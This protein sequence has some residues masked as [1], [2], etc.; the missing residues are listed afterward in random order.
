MRTERLVGK[1]L[2]VPRLIWEGS[3]GRVGQVLAGERFIRV[4]GVRRTYRI[5]RFIGFKRLV[6][7][8]LEH[9]IEA[10]SEQESR[11]RKAA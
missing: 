6:K 10:A 3:F 1:L 5:A 8:S 7:W 4:I 2:R 11:G 9:R